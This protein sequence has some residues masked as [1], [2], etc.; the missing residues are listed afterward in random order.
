M[1][2]GDGVEVDVM[3]ALGVTEALTD[4]VGVMDTDSEDVT[5]GEGDTV[6]DEVTVGLLELVTLT[7]RVEE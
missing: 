4:V 3:E 7:V 1:N 5:L 6:A 2:V